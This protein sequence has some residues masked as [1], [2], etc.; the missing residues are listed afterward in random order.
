M[1]YNMNMQEIHIRETET[2]NRDIYPVIKYMQ[3]VSIYY[4]NL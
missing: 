1:F 3:S 2:G 4:K